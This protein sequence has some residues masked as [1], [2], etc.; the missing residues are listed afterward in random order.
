MEGRIGD[1][2]SRVFYLFLALIFLGLTG[3]PPT[4]RPQSQGAATGAGTG[5]GAGAGSGQAGQGRGGAGAG[6]SE[7]SS[8]EA[9]RQGE[10]PGSSGPL[11]EIY[12]DYDRYDV[13]A[14]A[15]EALKTNAEWL[16]SNPQVRVQIE[17]HADERG[18][19]E[20]N[21]ALGAKRAQAAKD[22]LVTLGI[23]E[24]RLTTISYGEEVPV[25]K[26]QTEDCWQKNRRA[27]FVPAAGKPGS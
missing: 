6:P 13:R 25:C 18:T 17:G 2:L 9:L 21:L 14:D 5:A 16:K 26:E 19:N 8:L 23:V 24:S 27:R 12:F 20:Y 10:K 22:Y 15:R 11:K 3:C 4:S 1:S 7:R